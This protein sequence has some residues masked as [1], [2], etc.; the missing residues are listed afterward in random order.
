MDVLARP[1]GPAGAG[2]SAQLLLAL[3]ALLDGHGIPETILTAPAADDFLA[4]DGN[5][6]ANGE[7]APAA[8]AALEQAGLLTVVPVTAPPTVRISQCCRR[9]CGPRYLKACGIKRRVRPRTRCSRPGR[10]GSSLAGLPPACNRAW[11]PSG[12]SPETSCGTAAAILC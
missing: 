4:G 2:R 9:R 1:G 10:K 3:T 6:P 12:G 11:R 5:L 7:T 8:L